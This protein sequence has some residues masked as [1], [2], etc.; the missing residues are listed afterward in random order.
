MTNHIKWL[1][2]IPAL[3][4]TA[5]NAQNYSAASIADSLKENANAVI[6]EYVKE[7]ELQSVNKGTDRIKKIITIL[8]KNGDDFGNLSISY[9][10]DSKVSIYEAAIYDKFGKKVK[11]INQSDISDSPAQNG[12]ALYS[13]NRVKYYRPNYGEYPYT[14][15]YEYEIAYTSLISYGMW[16]PLFGYNISLEHSKFTFVHPSEIQCK[17]K[18]LNLSSKSELTFKGNKA[19]ETW[20]CNPIKAIEYEPFSIS[21]SERLPKVYI[22]PVKLMFDIYSGTANNWNEYGKWIYQL[23]AGRDQIADAEKFIIARQLENGHDTIGKIKLLYQYM[24][25]HTR[26]VGIQLGIGGFQPFPAQTVFETGYGDCK[27]LTNYMHTLLRQIG[28]ESYPALVS[29]GVYIEPIFHD[30][31]NFQQFDHVILCVPFRKDTIWLEC[32]SQTA[33]FGFLGD[34]T[35]DRDV[36]L[37]T[38]EGGKLAHTKRYGA[39]DNLLSSKSEFVIDATGNASCQISTNYKALQYN[40]ISELFLYNPDEQKKWLYRNA[41]LPSQQLI[42]Y[43]I[44]NFKEPIPAATIDESWVSKNYC[45]FTGNYMILPLNLVNVQTPIKKMMKE[46]KSDFI[47]HRSTADYDTLVYKVPSIYKI[48]SLPGG[49]E[50]KSAFG[51][52]SYTVTAKDNNIIYSRKFVINQGRFKAAEYKNF[53][54]FCLAVSKADNVKVMLAK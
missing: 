19:I 16:Y 33:P 25:E 35:D 42:D 6:R 18:E 15:E 28:L 20:Q 12:G 9:D 23:Y 5:V 48:E 50:I 49:K 2:M 29:S 36:L 53:Y 14:V 22:M 45:S 7:F 8:D 21:L 37:I 34:F 40:D 32:T 26:Y 43:H 51:D 30:F 31:P 10:K 3:L 44:R 46:R 39:D 11:K 4:F 1:T 54:E 52:F 24:Q 27:A 41:T 38:N 13:D 47:I 17:K